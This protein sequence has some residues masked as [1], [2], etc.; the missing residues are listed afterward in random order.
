MNE[1]EAKKRAL[2]AESE[3]YRETLKLELHNVQLYVARTR[4]KLRSFGKPNPLL[5]LAAPL[6]GALF[7]KPRGA[8][9]RRG[10][11]AFLGWQ[12]SNRVMPLLSGLFGRPR[13]RAT[14]QKS[15]LTE[16]ARG[17]EH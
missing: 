12:V 4:Q 16:R 1:L 13:A 2:V 11:M 3:V 5:M 10:A 14:V 17:A 9:L 8:W 6:A 7:R 15:Q